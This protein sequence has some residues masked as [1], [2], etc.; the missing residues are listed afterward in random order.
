[1][2]GFILRGYPTG[3]DV[4]SRID[5][6]IHLSFRGD[7]GV[8]KGYCRTCLYCLTGPKSIKEQASGT[9]TVIS[10]RRL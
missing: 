9:T 6:L 7:G 8:K 1:M 10:L 3:I 5:I 4:M 2:G